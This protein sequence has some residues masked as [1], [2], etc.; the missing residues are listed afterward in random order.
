MPWPVLYR[1]QH[2]EFIVGMIA[3]CAISLA[4]AVVAVRRDW[5]IE[6]GRKMMYWSIGGALLILFS[7]AAFQVASNLPLLQTVDL[8]RPLS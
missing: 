5:R 6:S 3:L 1:P 2:I 4:I 8:H 7:C